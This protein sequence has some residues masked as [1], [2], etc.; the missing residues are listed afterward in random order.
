ME[1]Q[2]KVRKKNSFKVIKRIILLSV[3]VG[4]L[5][6]SI[7]LFVKYSVRNKIFSNVNNV[8]DR[9]FAIVLGAGIKSNGT[10]G[11]YLT[12]RLNAALELYFSGKVKRILLTGDNSNKHYDEI[13]VMNNYLVK[14]GVPQNLI[15]ADYAGFDTYSSM[16]RAAEIFA[17]KEA[18][19]IS[20]GYH[21]PRS[22]YIAQ[23]KG[24]DAI[25]F[26]TNSSYGKRRYFVREWAATIKSF[27]DCIY[28]R[29]AK[30]YGKKVKTNGKSNVRQEQL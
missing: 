15:F 26:T 10:P 4:S 17:I 16:E 3:I 23:Y 22:V 2:F 7:P 28:N 25:G 27:V 13:S 24:I 30:F 18:I 11:S 8:D 6:L 1:S 5:I 21:L 20:Q 12:Q 19:V 9:E 29:R 14:K